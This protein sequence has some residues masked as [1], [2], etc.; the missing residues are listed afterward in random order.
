VRKHLATALVVIA[1]VN[2]AA[3]LVAGQVIGGYAVHGALD[4]GRY[5]VARTAHGSRTEVSPGTYHYLRLHERSMFLTHF[6]AI[7]VGWALYIN[8]RKPAR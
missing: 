3:Y 2:F 7:G 6:L 8:K 5:Y 1:L 4:S